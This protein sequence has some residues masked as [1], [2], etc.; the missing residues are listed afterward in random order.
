MGAR[1]L[2]ELLSKLKPA[3]KKEFQAQ[4]CDRLSRAM[5]RDDGKEQEVLLKLAQPKTL[6]QSRKKDHLKRYHGHVLQTWSYGT[7]IVGQV[8]RNLVS[9]V[10][11][12][13][14]GFDEGALEGLSNVATMCITSLLDTAELQD[15]DDPVKISRYLN[16]FSLIEFFYRLAPRQ[17]RVHRPVLLAKPRRPGRP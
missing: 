3:E 11:T 14:G 10:A 17:L 1:K 16:N 12:L 13:P 15:D 2:S 4:L 9:Q 6:M 8:G 5:D 7:D